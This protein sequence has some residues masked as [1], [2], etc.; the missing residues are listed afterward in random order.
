VQQVSF[1]VC[2][3]PASSDVCVQL[4]LTNNNKLGSCATS[5]LECCELLV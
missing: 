3:Q 4:V 2:A 5:I 1:G